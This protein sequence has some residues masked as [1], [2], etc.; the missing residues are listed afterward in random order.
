MPS[1]NGKRY[2]ILARAFQFS[3]L[4]SN[5]PIVELLAA[6]SFY[7]LGQIMTMKSAPEAEGRQFI[8]NKLYI[9]Q[10]TVI[11]IYSAI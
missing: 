9:R 3:E 5:Q 11:P 2:N 7:S 1:D 10:D 6:S 4:N 8:F